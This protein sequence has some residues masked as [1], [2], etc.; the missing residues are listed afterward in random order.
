M[1]TKKI[2]PET[3][4]T[5]ETTIQTWIDRIN[6]IDQILLENYLTIKKIGW[7][8][9]TDLRMNL[10]KNLSEINLQ[11]VLRFAYD[12]ES[13]EKLKDINWLIERFPHHKDTFKK[14]PDYS[15]FY[16]NRRN[17]SLNMTKNDFLFKYFFE[18]EAK[19]RLTVKNIP[20]AILKEGNKKKK[21]FLKG[22]EPFHEIY[23][24]LLKTHL[25]LPLKDYEVLSL[26]ST[27][28]NTIHNSGF[29][30]STKGNNRIIRFRNKDY[31]FV[32]SKPINFLSDELIEQ[33]I[34]DL[35]SLIIKILN[36]DKIKE[37][38]SM[39]DPISRITF[40]KK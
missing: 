19:L 22:T 23:V 9:D 18:I 14:I 13:F 26:S 31:S 2:T 25:N 17:I 27:I 8:E 7:N 3:I 37:I 30:Y 24:G 5:K 20:N 4:P 28:R 40:F 29:Y 35:I 1:D 12:A 34:L 36:H 16:I 39:E 21:K 6:K 11:T 10:L 15:A 38:E 32:H 33:I